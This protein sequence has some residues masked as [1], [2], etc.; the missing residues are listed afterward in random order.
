MDN[1]QKALEEV[2]RLVSESAK[3]NLEM[4]EDIDTG[5][6]RDSINYRI[7][8]NSVIIGTEVPYAPY[9][10]LGTGLFAFHGDGRQTPWR[11]QDRQG[12]WHT[13]HGIHSGTMSGHPFLEPALFDNRE[14]I[15][16]LIKTAVLEGLPYNERHK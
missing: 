14:A 2:G 10:E 9:I 4:N 7:E 12:N 8:G 6:L 3:H 1:L 15:V 5:E 11:W 16:R 13:T